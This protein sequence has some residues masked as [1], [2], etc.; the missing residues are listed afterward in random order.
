MICTLDNG[1]RLEQDKKGFGYGIDAIVLSYFARAKKG[2]LVVDLGTGNAVV[3]LLMEHCHKGSSFIGIEI[4]TEAVDNA[5]KSVELNNRQDKVK[6][7]QC[8]IKDSVS[9]LGYNLADVVVSNPPYFA[10]KSGSANYRDSLSFA[11]HEVLCTL[12]DVIRNALG[13]LK[14]NG[15]FYMVH[16]PDRLQEI[17]VLSQKYKAQV[18]RIRLVYPSSDSNANIVL[19]EIRPNAR[20]GLIIEPPLI[21]YDKESRYTQSMEDIRTVMLKNK[22]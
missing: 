22:S 18:K 10:V 9:T 7:L 14:C 13:I 17:F 6:V 8:N 16:R 3:P 12:E 2:D 5:L 4:Q 19:V 1:I 11:R 21:V 15:V 20:Q